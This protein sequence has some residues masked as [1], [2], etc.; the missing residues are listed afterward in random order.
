[1]V[2]GTCVTNLDG[3][4]NERWPTLFDRTPNI[5]ES[6]QAV[7]GKRLTVV[8]ITHAQEIGS[9]E[10]VPYIIVELSRRWTERR[11]Q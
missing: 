8:S 6:V 1:M 10:P 11:P 3:Y 9:E 4:Q 7:S 2:R 5:G